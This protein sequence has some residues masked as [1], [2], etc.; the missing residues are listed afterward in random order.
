MKQ[1]KKPN[2][3]GAAVE[4]VRPYKKKITSLLVLSS[5]IS[6]VNLMTLSTL[7]IWVSLIIQGIYDI[8]TLPLFGRFSGYIDTRVL[9]D[10]AIGENAP[11]F[12]VTLLLCLCVRF[13]LE[14]STGWIASKAQVHL[15]K[16][17]HQ[18]MHNACFR[19]K[20]SFIGENEM[21]DTLFIHNNVINRCVN[22]FP[23]F[24]KFVIAIINFVL[25]FG[26]LLFLDFRLTTILLILFISFALCLAVFRKQLGEM[27]DVTAKTSRQLSAEFAE[28]LAGLRLIRMETREKRA[29]SRLF[30]YVQKKADARFNLDMATVT[31]RS[32]GE[33]LLGSTIVL[34]IF[35]LTT[36]QSAGDAFVTLS[37]SYIV[38][39]WAAVAFFG[40]SVDMAFRLRE[41]L[42]YVSILSQFVESDLDEAEF[43]ARSKKDTIPIKISSFA[44]NDLSF[45]HDG[46]K[47]VVDE[48]SAKFSSGK[49]YALLGPSG[50]GKSTML[51]LISSL[52][53][54]HKGYFSVNGERFNNLPAQEWRR[55]VAYF[56]QH[57]F[58]FHGTIR[59]NMHFINDEALDSEIWKSL[60]MAALD[61]DVRN[62][63]HELDTNL[64]TRG[65]LISGGQAQRLSI[66]RLLLKEIDIMLLDEATASLDR[67]TERRVLDRISEY[68]KNKILIVVTHRV[69]AVKDFDELFVMQDGRVVQRGKHQDLVDNDGGLYNLLIN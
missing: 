4:L 48:V 26:M 68:A 57:S 52:Q 14:V 60:E 46:I 65:S 50:A 59:E 62:M 8:E 44:L 16:R 47:D 21:G 18:R 64:G 53:R 39:A 19:K 17:L 28:V 63:Q 37:V 13:V 2:L 67:L 23:F 10:L 66:A 22:F 3:L 42:T 25:F 38:L 54:P 1:G 30:G 6:F 32:L 24:Q 7:V 33:I 35:L 20:L 61:S 5:A 11:V 56:S 27:S 36:F 43:V 49:R 55:R 41:I 31:G 15:N 12:M 69:Q 58:I 40:R 51:E 9:G 29:A 45:S 34:L